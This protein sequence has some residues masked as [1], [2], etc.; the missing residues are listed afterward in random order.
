MVIDSLDQLR[1]IIIPHFNQYPLYGTKQ[2]AF[3][4]FVSIVNIIQK[5]EHH[6]KKIFAKLIK[7]ALSMNLTSTNTNSRQKDLFD[8][9]GVFAKDSEDSSNLHIFDSTIH[10]ELPSIVNH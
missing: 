9:I 6:N 2:H 5:K 1:N 4:V 8:V 7:L 3:L 10:L